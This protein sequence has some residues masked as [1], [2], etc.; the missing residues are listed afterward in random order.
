MIVGS[1]S[2][3]TIS[4]DAS[5]NLSSEMV[6]SESHPK[7]PSS[8]PLEGELTDPLFIAKYDYSARTDGDLGFKRGDLLYIINSDDED[9]WL[10]RAKHSGQEGYIPSNYVVEYKSKLDTEM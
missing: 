9:W 5:T 6:T 8:P 4:K 10:A 7:S 2:S 1:K 3:N